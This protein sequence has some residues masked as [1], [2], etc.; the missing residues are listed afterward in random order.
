MELVT[1]DMCFRYITLPA[2]AL[3]Y[4]I[5]ERNIK[6]VRE[7]ASQRMGEQF[8][9]REFHRT[10]IRCQGPLP[11]L[12]TCVDTWVRGGAGSGPRVSSDNGEAD[13]QVS[14]AGRTRVVTSVLVIMA[15]LGLWRGSA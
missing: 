7:E 3:A 2:Q 5:G 8:D 1:R 14:G 10:V 13:G 6:K 9:I 11:V 15:A 12:E 4:K